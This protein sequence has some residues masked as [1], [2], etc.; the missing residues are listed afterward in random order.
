[1]AKRAK[2][3]T[4]EILAITARNVAETINPKPSEIVSNTFQMYFKEKTSE[5]LQSKEALL[6]T[7]GPCVTTDND[8]IYSNDIRSILDYVEEKM[9]TQFNFNYGILMWI[10]KDEFYSFFMP[11]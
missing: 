1:M 2:Y 5:M 8:G 4:E 11:H 3:P 6:L 10:C 9:H 7:I